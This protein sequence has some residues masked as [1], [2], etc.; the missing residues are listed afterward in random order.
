MKIVF[1]G[2]IV[3]SSGRSAVKEAIPYL[4]K[5]YNVDIYIANCENAAGGIGVTSKIADELFSMGINLLSSGNH[6]WK[7]SDINTYLNNTNKLIRPLNYPDVY[8]LP[9][10][11]YTIYNYKGMDL[12]LVN[13]L[14]RVFME[15]LLCPFLTID[16]LLNDLG[17][18]KIIIVDFHAEATSEKIAMAYYLDGRVTAVLGTHTHVQTAD[19]KIMPKGTAYITDVGMCGSLNSVIGVDADIIIERLITLRPVKFKFSNDKPS[20][21]AVYLELDFEQ[22]KVLNFE[23]INF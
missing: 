7:H 11:G 20:I 2:D 14:G 13:L 21:N 6:V 8:N 1:F 22:K 23:R 4:N 17:K 3:A 15:P 12:V 10:F 18:D 16:N 19:N 9:G 5:Q